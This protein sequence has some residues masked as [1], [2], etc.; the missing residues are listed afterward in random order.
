MQEPIYCDFV[1]GSVAYRR[2]FGENQQSPMVRAIHTSGKPLA[3]TTVFDATGGLCKDAFVLASLGCKVEVMEQNA[4]LHAIIQNGI[5]R[6]M[7]NEEV[8]K[9]LSRITL[10]LG[11]SR[12][13]MKNITE[14]PD[15]VYLDPMYPSKKKIKA[16][17]KKDMMILRQLIG[18]DSDTIGLIQ[19]AKAAANASVVLKRPYYFAP[20]PGAT[21][22]YHSRGTHYDV[23]KV[24][25]KDN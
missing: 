10:R 25:K 7:Q 13:Y 17:S 12:E 2:K 6:G 19:I 16:L 14:K 3:E 22:S 9:I 21:T 11:D 5:E 20:D 4:V 18:T 15:V 24:D 1:E 8:A 23:Y